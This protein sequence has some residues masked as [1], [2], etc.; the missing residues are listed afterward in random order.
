MLT[1]TDIYDLSTFDHGC[2]GAAYT[3]IQTI[4]Y[5]YIFLYSYLYIT[6]PSSAVACTHSNKNTVRPWYP[7]NRR[8]ALWPAG[9][10]NAIA[11]QKFKY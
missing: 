2:E 8:L 1:R 7:R 10:A 5:M 6:G 11:M 3:F 4:E 9:V